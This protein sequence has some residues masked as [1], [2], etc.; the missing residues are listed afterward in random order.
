MIQKHTEQEWL[1]LIQDCRNSSMT[2]KDWCSQHDLTVKALYY[3]TYQ[4]RKKGYT[5]PNKTITSG[6]SEKHE[7]V[8]LDITDGISNDRTVSHRPVTQT[9]SDTALRIN[10]NGIMIEVSNH[11]AQDTITNTF[12][13]LQALC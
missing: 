2:V 11:A 6:R 8:C 1:K 12:R 13:A 10:F 7:I 5:I 9:V 4:L 3:H